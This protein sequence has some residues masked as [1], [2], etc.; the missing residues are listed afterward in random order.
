[1]FAEKIPTPNQFFDGGIATLTIH[2]WTNLETAFAEL[3]RVFKP[4]GRLVIFTSTPEQ[5]TCY[6]LNHYF[7]R[8]MVE[9]MNKM[10]GLIEIETTAVK[11]GFKL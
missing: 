9:S 4:G 10:P 5:M 3:F 2:H 8:M 1:V 7:P 11:A 6:W